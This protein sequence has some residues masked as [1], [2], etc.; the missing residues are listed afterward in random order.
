[1]N[2]DNLLWKYAG[3]TAQ[4]LIGIGLFTFFGLKI[5]G[6]LKLKTPLAVW[7]LPLVFITAIIIK[8]IID[9]SRKK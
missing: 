4:F 1:M 2:N 6:F 3:L 5:D 7:V 9:T 8:V